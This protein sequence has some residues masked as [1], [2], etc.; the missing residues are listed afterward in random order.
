MIGRLVE[1]QHVG[2]TYQLPGE[3]KPASFPAAKV[4]EWLST[5][6]LCIESKSLQNSIHPRGESVPSFAI[7]SLE[8]LVVL[9]QKLRRC[10]LSDFGENIGLLCERVL[11]R[12]EIGKFSGACFPN[13]F[14]SS[15]VTMLLQ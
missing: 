7:K 15:E 10:S 12:K 5:G 2:C 8:V 4:G 9:C 1:E 11:Q 6:F 14:G 13:G 3:T